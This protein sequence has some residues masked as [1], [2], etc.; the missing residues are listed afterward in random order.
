MLELGHG[1]ILLLRVV[2]LVETGPCSSRR[3]FSSSARST[4]ASAVLF[5]PIPVAMEGAIGCPGDDRAPGFA[6][7]DCT[8]GNNVQL[9]LT[10]SN[11]KAA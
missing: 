6:I 9:L 3:A 11:A 4:F 2:D 10:P 5:A 8:P 1:S 7:D